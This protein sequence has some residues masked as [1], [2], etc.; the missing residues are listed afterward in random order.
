LLWRYAGVAAAG[1]HQEME[2]VSRNL[3]T[4]PGPPLGGRRGE[5][6]WVVHTWRV[7]IY[8]VNTYIIYT[9]HAI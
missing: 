5:P 6:G 4:R 8:V 3:I 9:G 2:T 7:Y 1:A